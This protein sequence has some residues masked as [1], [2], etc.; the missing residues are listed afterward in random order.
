MASLN[1]DAELLD[2]GFDSSQ[3]GKDDITW[4]AFADAALSEANLIVQE[5]VGS[6]VYASTDTKIKNH[7]KRDERFIAARDLW[8]KR[9]NRIDASDS[10]AGDDLARS[11]MKADAKNSVAV[12]A[13]AAEHEFA[14]I[15]GATGRVDS[16][17]SAPSIGG[18]ISGHTGWYNP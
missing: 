12:Y 13:D 16:Q 14:Q 7:M 4:A 10:M 17:S 6:T 8:Q 5:R 3:F 18:G 9:M 15:I 11:R 2:E 1:T